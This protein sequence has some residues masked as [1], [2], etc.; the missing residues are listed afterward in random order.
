MVVTNF[1][2]QVPV[3]R[4]VKEKYDHLLIKKEKQVESPTPWDVSP[5]H[6]LPQQV[7]N[8]RVCI[9]NSENRQTQML[10]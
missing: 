8:L 7:G 5:L 2:F 9:V 6:E 4:P 10:L 1:F 3:V